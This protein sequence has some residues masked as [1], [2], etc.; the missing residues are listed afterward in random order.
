MT[1]DKLLMRFTLLDPADP[2]RE[3]SLVLDI[4]K[5]DYSGQS[6]SPPRAVPPLIT[7]SSVLSTSSQSL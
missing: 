7:S 4:S 3:F 6:I 2:D 1:E 5:Q